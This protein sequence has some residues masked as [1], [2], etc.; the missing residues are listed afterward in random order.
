MEKLLTVAIPSYNVEKYLEQ[1]LSSFLIDPQW[2]KKTEIL[3]VNDGSS[4]RTEEIGRKYEQKYP[5]VF[6]VITKENG[7]HG[8][9]INRGILESKGKYFKVVDGDDWVETQGFEN[10][11]KELEN[12]RCDFVITNYY[13][14]NDT[15]KARKEKSFRQIPGKK[16]LNIRE[17]LEKIQ[18]PMHGLTIRTELLKKNKIRLDEHCFYV[19]VEYI[20]FP[21]PY[22]ESVW[23]LDEYV[24]MYRLAVATQSVSM[25]GYQKHL[26]NHIDVVLHLADFLSSYM[27]K[28]GDPEKINYMCTR[29]SQMARDQADIFMSFP[30][31]NK[32]IREKFKRFDEELKKRNLKVYEQTG[33]YSGMLRLLRKTC[34]LGYRW[35]MAISKKR[36]NTTEP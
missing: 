16:V 20:L 3:I 34:F 27:A 35:I 4:D 23:Y 7:G 18:I 25:A 8:S 30:A 33:T 32:E 26:Q 24:Y 5:E 36:N 22:A 6:R 12:C 9:A 17:V 1:T 11:V 15:T 28:G 21:V 14:V 19:D 13:E 2:L 31:S 29:I 10:L